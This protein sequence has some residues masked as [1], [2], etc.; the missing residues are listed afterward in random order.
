MEVL[1][2]QDNMAAM[3]SSSAQ[4]EFVQGVS[5]LRGGLFAATDVAAET[6]YKQSVVMS[7]AIYCASLTLSLISEI[8]QWFIT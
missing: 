7:L 3:R 6:A 5:M 8:P 1:A 4:S 2:E